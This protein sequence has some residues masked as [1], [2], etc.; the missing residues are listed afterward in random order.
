M[1]FDIYGTLLI[2]GSGD[3]SATKITKRELSRLGE[4]LKSY[5]IPLSPQQLLDAL[6]SAIEIEHRKMKHSGI[7]YP[8]VDIIRIWKVLL[9]SVN[10]ENLPEFALKFELIINPVYP[11]P[12]LQE[13][14]TAC[15]RVGI[16]M[17]IISNAQFYT[18]IIMEFFLNR[19]LSSMGFDPG[20]TVF[21]Y[22]EG[23]AKPS[24]ELFEKVGL[25]LDQNHIPRSSTLYIGNDALNDI[26]PAQEA[27]FQTAL[28]AGDARSLR[29]RSDDMR[30]RGIS[31]NIIVSDLFQLVEFV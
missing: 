5:Q 19:S 8:E 13:L 22:L 26:R 23:R 14:L 10:L 21:S 28:Y 7:D 15:K 25:Y 20:L 27:G 18:P 6:F 9:A 17:G 24:L 29:L 2:S 30:C 11:M 12:H 16:K 1:V 3:V 4:L 31:V